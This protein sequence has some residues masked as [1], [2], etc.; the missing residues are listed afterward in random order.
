MLGVFMH[1]MNKDN[2]ELILSMEK[3]VSIKDIL[4]LIIIQTSHGQHIKGV[5]EYGHTTGGIDTSWKIY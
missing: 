5:G 3:T 4:W 1:R 2:D